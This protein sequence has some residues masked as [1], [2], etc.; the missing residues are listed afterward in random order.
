MFEHE[1]ATLLR[2]MGEPTVVRS[3]FDGEECVME[4]FPAD[5]LGYCRRS[6]YLAVAAYL[7]AETGALSADRVAQALSQT[8]SIQQRPHLI[9]QVR[10]AIRIFEPLISGDEANFVV[11][12]DVLGQ[13]DSLW[14]AFQRVEPEPQLEHVETWEKWPAWEELQRIQNPTVFQQNLRRNREKLDSLPKG[15]SKREVADALGVSESSAINICRWA[16]YTLKRRSR[17]KADKLAREIAVNP[18]TIPLVGE[19][20]LKDVPPGLTREELAKHL[21]VT[22]AVASQLGKNVGYEFKRKPWTRKHTTNAPDAPAASEG[23]AEEQP[24]SA[25]RTD[26]SIPLE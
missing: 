19:S 26:G 13:A 15:C 7:A 4:L 18:E 23:Q 10:R 17:A 16:G 24:P 12:G 22:F 21:G 25:P 11:T 9:S 2:E 6:V 14:D 8:L 20:P 3:N 1:G 5:G